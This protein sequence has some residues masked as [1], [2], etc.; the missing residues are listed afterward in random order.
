MDNDN[1][2]IKSPYY[3]LEEAK[4]Y[5]EGIRHEL[6]NLGI[7]T[8]ELKDQEDAIVLARLLFVAWIGNFMDNESFLSFFEKYK[9][10]SDLIQSKF[11]QKY[12]VYSLANIGIVLI[13][14]HDKQTDKNIKQHIINTLTEFKKVVWQIMY[15]MFELSQDDTDEIIINAANDYHRL[16]STNPEEHQGFYLEWATDWFDLIGIKEV[17]PMVLW[18]ISHSWMT[19]FVY[20]SK[21]LSSIFSKK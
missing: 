19:K 12:L 9:N 15:E 14:E 1:K 5:I 10:E 6:Q 2:Y 7:S 4:E 16:I 13:N 3:S 20:L 11:I 21:T 8:T 18:Q 17:N